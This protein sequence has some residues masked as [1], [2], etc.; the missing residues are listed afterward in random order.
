[1]KTYRTVFSALFPVQT[2]AEEGW[3]DYCI[4]IMVNNDATI[5]VFLLRGLAREVRHWGVFPEK[6]EA[7]QAGIEVIPLEMPGAGV[8]H[9]EKSPTA[10]G[11]YVE[12]IR[13]QYLRHNINGRYN[14]LLGVSLGGMIAAQWIDTYP[15]DFQSAVLINSSS[16]LSPPW[17]R[18]T[19][20]GSKAV[21]GGLLTRN[22]YRQERKIAD[23]VCNLE[24]T[25]KIARQWSDIS[26]SAPIARSNVLRQ[27]FAASAFSL[28]QTVEV[29]VLILS[30]I[31]DRLVSPACSHAIAEAWQCLLSSHDQAGHDLTTD[32]P[33]W[34]VF[35]I[36]SWLPH[37]H[38]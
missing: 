25:E 4:V 21:I 35:H 16:S 36:L 10:I 28:P 17:K 22:I 1:M 34:C 33:D 23:I 8:L 18:I 14:V 19:P 31:R 13:R 26:K 24:N 15:D 5:S 27:L 2:F 9:K 30:S 32:D 7:A 29:P 3:N 38:S 11:E 12:R 6:L 20:A 37:L